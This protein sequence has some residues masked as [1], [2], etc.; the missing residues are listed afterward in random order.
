MSRAT[1]SLADLQANRAQPV[2]RLARGD[3]HWTRTRNE[4]VPR[5]EAHWTART[6]ERVRR[7]AANS[8]ARLTE[9][10][11]RDIRARAAAGERRQDIATRY[12]VSIVTVAAVVQRRRWAHIP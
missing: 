9:E 2:R 12:N 6:P 7:G 4:D 3:E 11:V 5:G 10:A 1:E 8:N